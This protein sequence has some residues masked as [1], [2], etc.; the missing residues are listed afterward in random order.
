MRP[1]AILDSKRVGEPWSISLRRAGSI[2][3][4]WGLVAFL[5]VIPKDSYAQ[6]GD[7]QTQATRSAELIQR[8]RAQL[9]VA[10]ADLTRSGDIPPLDPSIL[11]E[12]QRYFASL[13]IDT[14]PI[15][16]NTPVGAPPPPRTAPQ[17]TLPGR[18]AQPPMVRTA[19]S[20]WQITMPPALAPPRPALPPP[21]LRPG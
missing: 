4:R 8:A 21:P 3:T 12:M 17:V 16:P 6:T 11:P 18:I 9:D 13:G 10:V 5:S 15:D 19:P 20:E 7:D 14:G 1:D 2:L